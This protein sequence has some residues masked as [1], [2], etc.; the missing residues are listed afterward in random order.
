MDFRVFDEIAGFDFLPEI[1]AGKE[2]VIDAVPFG[3]ARRARGAG[4]G[5]RNIGMPFHDFFADAGFSGPAGAGQDEGDSKSL[6]IVHIQK[7]P[8]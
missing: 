6:D 7:T 4:D 5:E 2:M 8:V 3:S 1:F